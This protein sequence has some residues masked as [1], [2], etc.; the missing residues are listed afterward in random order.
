MATAIGSLFVDL[1]VNSAAFVSDLGKAQ[2]ALNSSSARMNRSLGGLARMFNLSASSVAG[3]GVAAG[4]AAVGGLFA[5]T[6]QAVETADRIGKAADKVGLGVEAFQELGHAASLA[7]VEQRTFEMAMQRFSRRVGEAVQGQGELRDTLRQY[8]IAVT[9]SGGKTR[10]LQDVLGDY[11]EAVARADSRQEQLRLSFK[12]FDSEGAALVNMMRRGRE[13]I[14]EMRAEARRLGIVIDESMIREAERTRDELERLERVIS[15]DMTTALLNL[16]PL[17]RSISAAMLDFSVTV[18]QAWANIFKAPEEFDAGEIE[19]QIRIAEEKI[20]TLR[21]AMD[22]ILKQ[23]GPLTKLDKRNLDDFNKELAAQG[24]ILDG[25]RARLREIKEAGGIAGAL[26]GGD[27]GGRPPPVPDARDVVGDLQTALDRQ[28]AAL[29]QRNLLLGESEGAIAKANAA[30]AIQNRL[31]DENIELT[32]GQSNTFEIYL[33]QLEGAA[34][35]LAEAEARQRDLER[36]MREAERTGQAVGRSVSGALGDM[37]L[38]FE[39]GADAARGL[40]R[41]IARIALEAAV[42]Q[43]IGNAIGGFVSGFLGGGAPAAPTPPASFGG[44][45]M[46]AQHGA[47]F[48]VG[49]R[50]GTDANLVPLALT[51]GE[52]VIVQNREQQ[53]AGGTG[54]TNIFQV[55]MRGASLEAVRRLEALVHAVNGSIE[56]RAVAAMFDARRRGGRIA[57]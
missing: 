50:G 13:G 46:A 35:R 33:E 28:I 10:A 52:R 40:A 16:A 32:E 14:A 7:G 18:K 4:I 36:A 15:T 43:P 22:L 25:W 48:T 30:A 37:V 9:D 57:A 1:S 47:D 19:N 38:G 51:K 53:R 20:A 3:L 17:L 21:Q 55:D 23:E 34:D 27:G 2:Q 11:A 29:E 45:F 5:L 31:L 49:G 41:A 12:A 26:G 8:G 24:R 39:K 6:K 44:G 56:K 42:L 54:T